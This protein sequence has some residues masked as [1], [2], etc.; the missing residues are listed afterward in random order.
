M[1]GQEVR[2]VDVPADAG[3][4]LGVFENL[5]GL[6]D[7][8]EMAGALGR[9]AEQYHGTAARAFMERLTA[10]LDA[11]P[12]QVGAFRRAF[13]AE[14]LSADADG[15]VRRVAGR[16]ALV[17]A[18]GEL[19]T[20]MGVTG[21]ESGAAEWAARR[22]FESW[23]L[24]RGGTGSQEE[25]TALAQVRL[26][27]E[28]HGEARFTPWDGYVNGDRATINRAGF[29]KEN[30]GQVEY[31]VLPETFK[32]E[33]CEGMDVRFVATLLRA[34]H[35]LEIGGEGRMDSRHRLP[36]I[37]NVR[38]YHMIPSRLEDVA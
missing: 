11:V 25:K 4:G 26:F 20:A 33:I 27:F 34:K 31:Y 14:T 12:S 9:A 19:A 28:R 32:T 17:A 30:N 7:G 29:M 10:N 37:G 2:L 3:A 18:G 22:C 16:F 8:A 38:C 13:L 6:T 35:V 21:W 36:G 1:A 15:Q 5:H 23:V 24:S